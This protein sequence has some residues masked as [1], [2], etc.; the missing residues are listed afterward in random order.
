M[1]P[2]TIQ[3]LEDWMNTHCYNNSYGIG[4]RSI[5]EGCG[6]DTFGSLYVWYSTERGKRQNL[7]YFRSEEEAVQYAYKIISED[8]YARRHLVGW[9]KSRQEEEA[10]CAALKSRNIKFVKEAVPINITMILVE[11]CDVKQVRDLQE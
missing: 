9:L 3:Q 5:G 6:L 10:L 8:K 1:P 4:N 7:Q 2:T 11:G